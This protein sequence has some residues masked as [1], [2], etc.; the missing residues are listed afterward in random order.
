M[1]VYDNPAMSAEKEVE[2]EIKIE[3]KILKMT[4]LWDIILFMPQ[5]ST[6]VLA[7]QPPRKRNFY[8]HN[9]YYFY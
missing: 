8:F 7:W 6:V 1:E 2:N 5:N 4:Q 9:I 3:L